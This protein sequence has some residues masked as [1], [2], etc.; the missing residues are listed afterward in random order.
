MLPSN[1]LVVQ[2]KPAVWPIEPRQRVCQF[3]ASDPYLR[4][5]E[6]DAHR[7]AEDVSQRRDSSGRDSRACYPAGQRDP[8]AAAELPSGEP[9]TQTE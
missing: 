2:A 1:T 9:F 5:A 6:D 4:E 7:A 3:P 8:V